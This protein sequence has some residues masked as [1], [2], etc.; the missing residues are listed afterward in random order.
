[1]REDGSRCSP[2]MLKTEQIRL[3]LRDIIGPHMA[4]QPHELGIVV[5]YKQR[6]LLA[7]PR[8][9]SEHPV[10]R[11]C[12][13]SRMFML[14]D[15]TGH[16][17]HHHISQTSH[18]LCCPPRPFISICNRKT[19][20]EPPDITDRDLSAEPNP[21]SQSITGRPAFSLQV[22]QIEIFHQQPIFRLD[23]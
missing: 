21:L 1:M 19:A 20:F 17:N 16:L 13:T 2:I 8:E 18:C 6:P 7:R 11:Q 15:G 10:S 4:P 9:P 5:G 22:L 3:G 23:L 12:V 14:A